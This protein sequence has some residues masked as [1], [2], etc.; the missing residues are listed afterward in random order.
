M[1]CSECYCPPYSTVAVW[2]REDKRKIF[3]MRIS[4]AQN[5]QAYSHSQTSADRGRS[6][7]AAPLQESAPGLGEQ[8]ARI[9]AS[10]AQAGLDRREKRARVAGEQDLGN[11]LNARHQD[12]IG[13]WKP[14]QPGEQGG[15]DEGEINCQHQRVRE[16]GSMQ[17]AIQSH[18]R[19]MIGGLVVHHAHMLALANTC[20]LPATRFIASDKEHLFTQLRQQSGEAFNQSERRAVG[21]RKQGLVASHAPAASPD[22]NHPR[23]AWPH[24]LRVHPQVLFYQGAN[25]KP[26]PCACCLWEYTARVSS[27]G[28][29]NRAP[30]DTP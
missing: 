26:R 1:F 2:S 29:N 7:A 27:G 19:A 24:R 18:Q 9:A 17:A 12:F 22:Q 20:I 23:D 6:R 11:A 10:G 4:P 14:A 21:E 15:P 8:G 5:P 30:A 13:E 25:A 28:D 3:T 16:R